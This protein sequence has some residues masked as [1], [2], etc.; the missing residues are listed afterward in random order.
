MDYSKATYQEI[1]MKWD[2]WGIHNNLEQS[3]G[4]DHKWKKTNEKLHL[5][6][7]KRE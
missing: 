3:L 2:L 7:P 1:I 6:N 4:A 5:R